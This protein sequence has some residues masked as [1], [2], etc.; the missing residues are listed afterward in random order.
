MPASVKPAYVPPSQVTD[1][2]FLFASA[3]RDVL[4]PFLVL[5]GKIYFT[6]PSHHRRY[7][8]A[9]EAFF[10]PNYSAYTSDRHTVLWGWQVLSHSVPVHAAYESKPEHTEHVVS[11]ILELL[12]SDLEPSPPLAPAPA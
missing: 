8:D 12:G 10:K 6:T 7:L 1:A 11:E 2:V 3:N 9:S 4:A 5:T